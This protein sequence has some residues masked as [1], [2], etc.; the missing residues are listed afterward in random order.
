MGKYKHKLKQVVGRG[1]NK[2][3]V[4]KK[5]YKIFSLHL[6]EK[7]NFFKKKKTHFSRKLHRGRCLMFTSSYFIFWSNCFL[8]CETLS[9]GRLSLP[10]S[11]PPSPSAIHIIVPWR[12]KKGDKQSYLL[13][14]GFHW[15][16]CYSRWTR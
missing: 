8:C 13:S 6:T 7:G 3:L 14:A 2:I 11:L 10:T 5:K 16:N 9:L 1:L 12:G 4:K 15:L